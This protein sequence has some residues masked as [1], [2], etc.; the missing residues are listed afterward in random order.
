MTDSKNRYLWIVGG[1]ILQLPLIKE[2]KKLSYKTIVTDGDSDCVCSKKADIFRCIDVFDIP[3]HITAAKNLRSKKINI[4]GV[5]AAGIDCHETMA[6]IAEF[7]CLPGVNS[8]IS[9]LVISSAFVGIVAKDSSDVSAQDIILEDIIFADTMSYR[10]KPHFNGAN[11]RIKNLNST[12]GNHITQ[13]MSTTSING[14]RIKPKDVDI[15]ALYNDVMKS[16]K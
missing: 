1:G 8:K 2:A 6:K 7:L 4:S 3:T 14:R 11:L 16:T 12:L 5:L 9:N 10:K 15:D 13:N